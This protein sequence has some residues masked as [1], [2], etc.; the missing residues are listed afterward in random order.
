MKQ[1]II[2]TSS[3]FR[4]LPPGHFR[5]GISR[6]TPRGLPAG[7]R[8]YPRLAPGPWFKTEPDP[9]AWS[10][11]YFDE[12]LAKLDP[13]RV[14]GELVKMVPGQV[15]V[16]VCFE[17]PPPDPRWCHRAWVSAWLHD[18]LAL[19]VPELGHE[20]CGCGWSHPKLPAEL[21]RQRVS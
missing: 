15:T 19:E 1:P 18:T 7:Y 10:R 5:V 2:R 12:I 3:W 13:A 16:L 9:L 6:G 17:P 8:R 20:T 4:P 14:V 11:R 21:R